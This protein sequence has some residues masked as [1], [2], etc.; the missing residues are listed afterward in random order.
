MLPRYLNDDKLGQELDKYYQVV[1]TKF[2]TAIALKA[3]HKF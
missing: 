2:F 3:A 1:T